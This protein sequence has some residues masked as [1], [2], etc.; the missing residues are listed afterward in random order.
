[1]HLLVVALF[2]Q[3]LAVETSSLPTPFIPLF[4]FPPLPLPAVGGYQP[5]SILSFI[6]MDIQRSLGRR[7]A[8]GQWP[9]TKNRQK[10]GNS[11][12][13]IRPAKL[14]AVLRPRI[15]SAP[16]PG[17]AA[18]Q[19]PAENIRTHGVKKHPGPSRY[20]HDF[21]VK[22]VGISTVKLLSELLFC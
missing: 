5:P 2:L 22:P 4:P 14:G 16:A 19:P 17:E 8:T 7:E 18:V 20:P 13:T 15:K 10:K 3:S 21:A 11:A 6:G 9:S 1:M 12:Q